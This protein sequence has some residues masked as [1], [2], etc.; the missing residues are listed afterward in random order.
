MTNV[1]QE[2]RD[3]WKELY[4]LFDTSYVMDG[5]DKSWETYWSKATDLI[6]KYGTEIDIIEMID[7]V[8]NLL[9]QVI[10]RR[11]GEQTLMWDKGEPYP[12]PRGYK[13][14]QNK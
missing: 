14:G 7:A 3:F 4:I 6:K 2:L 9:K 13:D 11:N 12:H 1:P 10:G 5:S 8:A